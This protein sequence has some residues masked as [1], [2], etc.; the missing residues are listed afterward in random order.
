M[1][2]EGDDQ[3]R[4]GYE[5]RDWSTEREPD[6][7]ERECQSQTE[8]MAVG[9]GVYYRMQHYQEDLRDEAS[10][11]DRAGSLPPEAESIVDDV[12]REKRVTQLAVHSASDDLPT[13]AWQA[14]DA[15]QPSV[16]TFYDPKV[17]QQPTTLGRHV[18]NGAQRGAKAAVQY[19]SSHLINDFDYGKDAFCQRSGLF[20]SSYNCNENTMQPGQ[21]CTVYSSDAYRVN[22]RITNNLAA[23]SSL[24]GHRVESKVHRL[25]INRLNI[26][27]RS[28]RKTLWL[29]ISMS[30]RK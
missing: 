17:V 6:L 2:A 20:L 29:C 10:V 3:P 5:G 14:G 26:S 4:S 22:P 18:T 30:V 28:R 7:T 25:S 24:R 9:D 15:T 27:L 8:W 23:A 19:R 11:E 16:C 13:R 21:Q 1:A 12:R